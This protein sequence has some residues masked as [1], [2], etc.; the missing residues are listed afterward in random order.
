M[1]PGWIARQA[2]EIAQDPV[3][4]FLGAL[5]ALTCLFNAFFFDTNGFAERMSDTLDPV[6]W[7]FWPDCHLFRFPWAEL[8]PFLVRSFQVLAVFCGALFLRPRSVKAAW[9]LLLGLTLC[10]HLVVLMSFENM[11]NYHYMPVIAS[12]VFLFLPQ[13]KLVFPIFVTMFY[14][15]ASLLKFNA[16]WLSGS[17]LWAPRFPLP[18]ELVRL[19]CFYVVLLEAVLVL[20]LFH[21]KA[22][23]RWAVFAQLVLFHL[24]STIWVGWFYPSIMLSLLAFFPLQWRLD[25]DAAAPA[26]ALFSGKL[27]P[28]NVAA[29]LLF[30]A[31]QLSPW[32]LGGRSSVS[33]EGRTFSLNMLDARVRCHFL[34]QVRLKDRVLDA[35][36][37]GRGMRAARI[38][39]DPMVVISKIRNICRSE[40]GNTDF[41]GV[42][43]I[44]VSKKSSD[45]AYR[46]LFNL[47]DACRRDL[48]ADFWGR[49][50]GVSQP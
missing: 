5:L 9:F 44:M 16:E 37:D 4:R 23:V 43:A 35:S 25:G 13:K 34:V 21:P 3:L 47:T 6:C 8:T 29:I 15:G 46:T 19:G 36:D 40:S 50:Q 14:L 20:L 27:R 22:V 42:D 30:A 31:A 17:A 49:F 24:V 28:V 7:Y 12:Y 32:A 2:Q 38:H 11:G 45:P 18:L 39:C 33:G 41:L 10:R 48:S 26:R 1:R